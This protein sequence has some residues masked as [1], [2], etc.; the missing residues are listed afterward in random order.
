MSC[1]ISLSKARSATIRLSFAFSSSNCF[2]RRI[3]GGVMP[4]YFFFQLK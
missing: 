2:S 3:Y 4:S 1:S